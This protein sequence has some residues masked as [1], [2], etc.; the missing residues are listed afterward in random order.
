MHE[1]RL[2]LNLKESRLR[3][4][5]G[6]TVLPVWNSMQFVFK[7]GQILNIRCQNASSNKSIAEIS[8]HIPNLKWSSYIGYNQAI[9]PGNHWP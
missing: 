4:Q 9:I 1:R 2:V 6:I 8:S 7:L 3:D 5:P